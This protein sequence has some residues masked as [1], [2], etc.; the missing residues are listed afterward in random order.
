MKDRQHQKIKTVHFT[1]VVPSIFYADIQIA[2]KT[3]I[4]CL[5]F[6]I[7]HDELHTGTEHYGDNMAD[8]YWNNQGMN[9][10]REKM[11][12]EATVK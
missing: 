10:A 3:F 7:G 5:E 4:D 12:E 11:K 1:K 9:A 6:K 2:L 8:F